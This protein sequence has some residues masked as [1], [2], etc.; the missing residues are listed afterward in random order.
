LENEAASLAQAYN[1]FHAMRVWEVVHFGHRL[2][3][4]IQIPCKEICGGGRVGRN[5]KHLQ[6]T[7]LPLQLPAKSELMFAVRS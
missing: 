2:A 1:L 6:A 7:R 5:P 3:Q 4:I